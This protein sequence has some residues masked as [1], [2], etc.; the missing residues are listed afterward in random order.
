M[1]YIDYIKGSP[2]RVSEHPSFLKQL[3]D[4]HSTDTNHLSRIV[5]TFN[6]WLK[7]GNLNEDDAKPGCLYSFSFQLSKLEFLFHNT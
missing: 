6:D 7:V 3:T 4:F 2:A 1:Y 5:T